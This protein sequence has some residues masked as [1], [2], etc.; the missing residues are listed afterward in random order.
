MVLVD[1]CVFIDFL[2]GKP[3]PEFEKLVK[4]GLV[5][6]S[7]IVRLELLQGARSQETQKLIRT[8]AGFPEAALNEETLQIATDL[9][10]PLKPK[11][12]TVG[13]PDLIIA[14]QAIQS[15]CRLYTFDQFFIKTQKTAWPKVK[16][17]T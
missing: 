8:L 7:P 17:Q 9:L 3:L 2:R 10:T 14:A 15:K 6:L 12:L 1:T 16:L 4:E 13:I 5:L 11:G